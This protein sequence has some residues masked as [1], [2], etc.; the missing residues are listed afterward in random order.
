MFSRISSLVRRVTY[1]RLAWTYP[2]GPLVGPHGQLFGFLDK[3]EYRDGQLVIEGWSSADNLTLNSDGDVLPVSDRFARADVD[4]DGDGASGFYA[5]LP[6]HGQ[7]IEI[8]ACVDGQP[9]KVGV[10]FPGYGQKLVSVPAAS[11]Y[12]AGV[13]WKHRSDVLASLRDKD[14]AAHARVV[15]R[16]GLNRTLLRAAPVFDSTLFS[17]TAEEQD[18]PGP[19]QATIIIP[20][21]NAFDLLPELLSRVARHTDVS[22]RLILVEDASPDPRVRPFLHDW[23]KGGEARAMD[24]DVTLL[25]NSENL[26]FIGSVNRAFAE[27]L[28]FGDPV[29]LLNSDA[30]VPANWASRLLSPLAQDPSIASVTPMS[31]DAEIFSIPEI[32]K[33]NELAPGQVDAIDAVLARNSGEI[34]FPEV[35]T[36]VGFCMAMNPDFLARNPG[37]DTVFGK[38]YG[39]EVD[40]CQKVRAQGGVHLGH[41]GLFVEHRGGCSFG[42]EAKLALVAKNNGIVSKRYPGYDQ[43]VQDFI[44]NDPLAV[45]RLA[46]G[47]AWAFSSAETP[48]PVYVAHWLGGGA[49]HYLKRRMKT[50]L[51]TSGAAVVLRVGGPQRWQIELHIPGYQ[52]QAATS[53]DEALEQLFAIPG[54]RRLVYSCAVGEPDPVSVPEVLLKLLDPVRDEIEILFHDFFPISP[55]YTLL[56]GDGGFTG[57]PV[58][59]DPDPVHQTTRPSG[60]VVDL[61]QWQAAWGKL[62]SAAD[63]LVVFSSSSRDLVQQAYPDLS[64]K[65]RLT[66]HTDGHVLPQLTAPKGHAPSIG[67][68]GDIG[69]QKGAGVIAELGAYLPRSEGRVTIIGRVDPNF[70]PPDHVTVHGRY[71]LDDLPKIAE[72]YGID[73]WFIPSIWP[74]TFCYTVREALSTGLPVYCFDLG[75]Q[76]EGTRGHSNGTVLPLALSNNPQELAEILTRK[77]H[78]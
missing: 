62:L 54:A 23:V 15:A 3:A 38:G 77:L 53:D 76:A 32:C 46:A 42:S 66:P 13:L 4:Q 33:I 58:P 41:G 50:D 52:I 26:G 19:S 30:M 55:S 21:Y 20:I 61:A 7:F 69:F 64:G 25:E 37:F 29:I 51:D 22:G 14:E 31:N 6:W 70:A 1:Q 5:T 73:R 59:G 72:G 24:L 56:N 49:E 65:I 12:L 16:L 67:I 9:A 71:D 10:P 35:P 60:E 34:A 48:V 43:G 78:D 40:W 45:P 63:D 8:E 75:A 74:E 17:D 57:A 47:L 36:G 39:E 27:A 11:V 28:A 44:R 2:G 68:L 18:E